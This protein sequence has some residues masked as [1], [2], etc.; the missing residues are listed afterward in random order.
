[1][2]WREGFIVRFS[3]VSFCF[4]FFLFGLFSCPALSTLFYAG[5]CQITGARSNPIR[6][7]TLF[8]L[9]DLSSLCLFGTQ[10]A[11]II[12]HSELIVNKTFAHSPGVFT[13]LI[14]EVGVKGCQ[15]EEIYSLDLTS[16]QHLKYIASS[17]F[18]FFFFF[19][20]FNPFWKKRRSSRSPFQGQCMA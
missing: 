16:L 11:S 19:F 3:R 10:E 1:V 12:V 9:S 13:A 4:L 18:F 20:F 2:F 15:V 17:F 5:L 14:E 7:H 8:P 6:V